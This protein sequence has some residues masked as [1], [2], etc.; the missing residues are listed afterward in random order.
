M[1]TSTHRRNP[2]FDARLSRIFVDGL[3]VGALYGAGG[4]GASHA[5]HAHLAW[6]HWILAVIAVTVIHGIL[7]S[8]FDL[9]A[10]RKEGPQHR[11]EAPGAPSTHYAWLAEG[12]SIFIASLTA[13]LFLFLL[14]PGI[15]GFSGLGVLC[16]CLAPAVMLSVLAARALFARLHIVQG[17]KTR[18]LLVGDDPATMLLLAELTSGGHPGY[19][20]KGLIR[21]KGSI[22]KDVEALAGQ[23]GIRVSSP[24]AFVSLAG[25]SDVDMVV[26]SPYIPG[27]CEEQ[28]FFCRARGLGVIDTLSFYREISGKLPLHDVRET[29]LMCLT[30]RC[31]ASPAYELLKRAADLVV[32]LVMLLLSSPLLLLSAALLWLEEPRSPLF[33]F[34]HYLGEHGKALR[35]RRLRTPAEGSK[36]QYVAACVQ[37][38]GIYRIPELLSVLTGGMSIVGPSP[39]MRDSLHRNFR[40][41]PLYY[42][43]LIVKPGITGWAQVH[44]PLSV[45][46]TWVPMVR[47]QY[48]LYY[49]TRASLSLDLLI[50]LRGIRA[51]FR[52]RRASR[53]TGSCALVLK[54]FA[55]RMPLS[56]GN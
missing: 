4:Y 13:A 10:W 29:T 2:L 27:N 15:P 39:L 25:R 50:I 8:F 28:A 22:R 40:K 9:Y 3:I 36:K 42:A 17:K 41:A 49:V 31:T 7:F 56:V 23:C 30:E 6:W 14:A 35:I 45:P 19:E 38:T 51:L 53:I 47:L 55:T 5:G 16:L 37:A 24:S 20:V 32:S 18:V 43:R 12:T 1:V 52:W 11:E 44:E 34:H 26:M 48:D 54:P 33:T 21:G 46:S